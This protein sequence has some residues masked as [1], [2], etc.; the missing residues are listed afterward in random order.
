MQR[1]SALRL[2]TLA[3]LASSVPAY[4]QTASVPSD[5]QQTVEELRNTLV[6]VMEALVQKGVLTREQAQ[7]I[8]A[9]AQAKTEAAAKEKA[10]QDAAEKDAVRVTYVPENIKTEIGNQV[11][12]QIKPDVVNEVVAQAKNEK[13]GVPGA[14]PEWVS[15]LN[16]YGDVRMRAE[17][18]NYGA[19]NAQSVYLNFDAI[20]T[21]GGFGKAGTAALLNVTEDR[22]RT[23]IRARLGLLAD[24]GNSFKADLRLTSGTGRNIN[25]TNQTLGAYDARGAINLDKAALI[26]DHLS[27]SMNREF[28]IRMG[29]FNNPYN[30]VSELVWDNDLT[31]EGLS[32]TYAL[33]LFGR[34]VD[35]MERGLYVTVGAMPLQEIELS[36]KD[37]W[38]YA[39]QLGT[40]LPFA[41]SAVFKLSGA[42]Y[43]FQNIAGTKNQPDSSLLDYTAPRFLSKGN[44]VFDIRNSTTDTTVNLFA[45][46][47]DYKLLNANLSLDFPVA[48]KRVIVAGEFVRNIGFDSAKVLARTGAEVE[49][50]VNGYDVSLSVGDASLNAFGAWRALFGYRYLER[51]AVLDAFTDSDFH[52]GGTDAKGYQFSYELGLSRNMS[53]KARLMSATEVDGPPLAID[54]YH[55]DFNGSF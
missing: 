22:F 13:W 14:L 2:A 32:A 4:A 16:F 36:N 50:K 52:L 29:R 6:S 24:L 23:L 44:T 10:K 47:A 41:E 51:D 8:V 9:N 43:Q 12:A 28:E 33:D 49:G 39:A 48:H 15:H 5:N 46:A 7:Q 1:S 26:W 34:K 30:V 37:K 17:Q 38:L 54:V 45:L 3:A 53:V 21:A 40:E 55:L 19:D 42:Y 18:A 27:P 31:F 35:K 25:T 11:A 20:N